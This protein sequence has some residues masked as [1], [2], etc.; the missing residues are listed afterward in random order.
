MSEAE[1]LDLFW[2][3]LLAAA[4]GSL[5]GLEREFRGHEAGIRTS[6]LVCLGAAAFGEV[7]SL[8][9]DSRIAAGVVQGIGFLGAGL[10]F[11]REDAISGVTTAATT[12]VLAGLGL[13]VA[14]ELWLTALLLTFMVVLM[15]EL[16]PLS[17]WVY[18]NGR[19]HAGEPDAPKD[20]QPEPKG[21]V[22]HP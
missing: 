19:R 16:S 20:Q 18:R 2:R 13:M 7:S 14:A 4:L 17:D 8:F 3:L 1:Q 10:I 9:G 15:L 5:V 6:S 11:K 22:R 21:H 12:W